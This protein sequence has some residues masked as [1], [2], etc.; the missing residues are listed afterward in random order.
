MTKADVWHIWSA[1]IE[2][3]HENET[4]FLVYDR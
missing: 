1:Q 2:G 3:M 4:E